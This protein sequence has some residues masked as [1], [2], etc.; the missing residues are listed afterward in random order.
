MKPPPRGVP[1]DDN[2]YFELITKAVFLAGFRWAVVEGKWP[3]FRRAFDEFQIDKVADYS[4]EDVERL[5]A[6]AGLVRNGRKIEGTVLNAQ[7]LQDIIAEHG[8]VKT[9]LDATADL[10]WPAR[11][12]AVSEPFAHFGDFGAYFF[13][14]SVGEAV[15]PHEQRDSWTGPVPPGSPEAL[16]APAG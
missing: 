13:L 16:Q 11:K 14:W 4:Q 10:P 6:D 8:S 2:G 15:P 7:A 9:W 12:K 3:N 5:L 1:T